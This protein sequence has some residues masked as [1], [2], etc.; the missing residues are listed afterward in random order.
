M[1]DMRAG[2]KPGTRV[3]SVRAGTHGVPTLVIGPDSSA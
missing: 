3:C 2:N 1:T